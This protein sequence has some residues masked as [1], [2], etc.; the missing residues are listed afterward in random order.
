MTTGGHTNIGGIGGNHWS[1]A[2]VYS[3]VDP[4]SGAIALPITDPN[5]VLVSFRSDHRV[6]TMENEIYSVGGAG[7]GFPAD[8]ERSEMR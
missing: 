5:S 7:G 6:V 2:V 3:T 8:F 4:S 1:A